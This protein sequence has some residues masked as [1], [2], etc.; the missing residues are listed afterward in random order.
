MTRMQLWYRLRISSDTKWHSSIGTST[1]LFLDRSAR[2]RKERFVRASTLLFL[3]PM[4]SSE[5]HQHFWSCASAVIS[6]SWANSEAC[7][8]V[9]GNEGAGETL[10]LWFVNLATQKELLEILLGKNVT[11]IFSHIQIC[12]V[13]ITIHSGLHSLSALIPIRVPL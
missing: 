11:L 9:K 7:A 8:H 6:I 2:K 5:L 3:L 13:T 4:L 10:G 12:T 1:S